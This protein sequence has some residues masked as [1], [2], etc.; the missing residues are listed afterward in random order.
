MNNNINIPS[1]G[2]S[3]TQSEIDLVVEAVTHGWYE[4]RNM[5]FEQFQ[6]EFGRLV[7]K[8]NILPVSNC[9]AAIHLSMLSAGI[10]V[11]DEVIVPDVTWVASV[12]PIVYTG[13]KPVFCDI[14]RYTWCI[15][16]ESFQ[17]CITDKTKAVIVVDLYGNMPD[18]D[19]ILSIA[20]GNNILVIEDAAEGLGATYNGKPAG[21][22]GDIS[23]FS[24]NATKIAV[25]GQGGVFATDDE[26]LFESAKRLYH[27]GMAKYTDE[28]TFWSLE[29]GYNY[30]WTNIQ[31]SLALAQI[32]RLDELVAQRRTL[33][34]WYQ[35]RLKDIEGIQLNS[36]P[37]NICNTYWVVSAIVDP[38]YGIKKEDFIKSFKK[39]NI[40]TRPFFYPVSSMPAYEKYVVD[41]DMISINSV[42]YEISPF[43]ISFPSAATLTE[44][45]VDIVCRAFKNILESHLLKK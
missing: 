4:S 43:G 5:H 26:K 42:A 41:K 6:N 13:A 35:D 9:T 1:A 29:V 20:R 18:I 11:G 40:D 21:S 15:D 31:A 12:A 28:T 37:E 19:Q 33:F 3:I 17:K 34:T 38:S 25:A 44:K 24:F 23:V 39:K 45:Q 22:F 14:D 36:E 30:Q 10:G 2:P 32:R 7:Q 8:K 27:H 16:P